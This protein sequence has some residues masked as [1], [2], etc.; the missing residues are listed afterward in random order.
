[1]KNNIILLSPTELTPYAKNARDHSESHILEIASSIQEFGWTRP[2]II[3][4][5]STILAGHGRHLAAL[6][7]KI[8]QVPC[9]QIKGLS[10]EQKMAY[11]LADNSLAEMS[12]WDE[13]ALAQELI[14]LQSEDFDLSL[15]GF[16]FELNEALEELEREE[17]LMSTRD[18]I[19]YTEN[20][21]TQQHTCPHCSF[22]F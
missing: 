9:I 1:M 4:E 13:E 21:K 17:R 11:I 7:L 19:D 3:D 6:Y 20:T 8:P 18:P 2:I 5:L 22:N 12:Q 10:H 14:D 15:T 16:N